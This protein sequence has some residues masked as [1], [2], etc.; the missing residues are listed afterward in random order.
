MKTTIL[1]ELDYKGNYERFALT[2]AEFKRF[3]PNT[4]QTLG[5]EEGSDTLKPLVHIWFK[6]TRIGSAN[7]IN[8]FTDMAWGLPESDIENGNLAYIDPENAITFRNILL[9]YDRI[10]GRQ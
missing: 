2:E 6:K 3:Y 10:L 8:F 9:Q 7:W 4:Y 5:C 1:V